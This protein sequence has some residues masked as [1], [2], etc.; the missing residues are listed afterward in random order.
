MKSISGSGLGSPH[1]RHIPIGPYA[2]R[3]DSLG[4]PPPH[5]RT[6]VPEAL[7][8][9]LRRRIPHGHTVNGM[10]RLMRH[11]EHMRAVWT[12]YEPTQIYGPTGHAI[13]GT[14]QMALSSSSTA[15]I[16]AT[17]SVTTTDRPEQPDGPLQVRRQR[18]CL[19]DSEH[20]SLLWARWSSWQ[21]WDGAT[22]RYAD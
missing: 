3:L 4:A 10:L 8:V 6:E 15:A 18:R 16:T 14:A 20:M 13:G 19:R 1:L 22:L 9:F 17:L 11:P 2:T 12:H 21:T 7:E 5:L